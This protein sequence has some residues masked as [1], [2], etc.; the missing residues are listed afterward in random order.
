MRIAADKYRLP[1][2]EF[3]VGDAAEPIFADD[4]LDGIFSSSTLHHVYTFNGYSRAAVRRAITSHLQC[5]REGGVF[6]LRD[7]VSPARDAYVLLD[8]PIEQSR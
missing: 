2:L 1:N 7:F 8:L 3:R 5:V 6:V 4:P